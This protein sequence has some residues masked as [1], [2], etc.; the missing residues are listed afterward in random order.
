[1]DF[2][3]VRIRHGRL[4]ISPSIPKDCVKISN[5]GCNG[6]NYGLGTGAQVACRSNAFC[7]KKLRKEVDLADEAC[8]DYHLKRE[9]AYEI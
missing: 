7:R 6:G 3:G 2:G 4:N 9:A 1:M 5:E 8:T